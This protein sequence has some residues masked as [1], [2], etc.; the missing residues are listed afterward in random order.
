MVAEKDVRR[1]E[2][3]RVGD[4]ILFKLKAIFLKELR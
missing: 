2:S 1:K 3:G 4:I